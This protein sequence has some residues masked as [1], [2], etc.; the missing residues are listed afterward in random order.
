MKSGLIL[1]MGYTDKSGITSLSL[2][3]PKTQTTKS[4]SAKFQTNV[5]ARLFQNKI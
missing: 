4:M 5:S 3:E 2:K 1:I